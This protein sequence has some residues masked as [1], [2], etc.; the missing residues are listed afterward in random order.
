CPNTTSTSVSPRSCMATTARALAM[1]ASNLGP[2]AHDAGVGHE[3]GDVGLAV[4]GH[5]LGVEP[6][7]GGQEG[8]ALAQDGDPRQ[9]GLERLQA[10]QAEQGA[11]VAQGAAPLLVVVGDVQRV[12]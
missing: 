6:V 9:P 10:Q 8:R 11:L 12:A 1:A 5:D 7:E 4:A 2:V 3:P